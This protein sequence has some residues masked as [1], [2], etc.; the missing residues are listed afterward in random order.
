MTDKRQVK[1]TLG[2]F[3]IT[4]RTGW[5]SA[6]LLISDS[7]GDKAPRLVTLEVSGPSDLS[8]IRERLDNIEDGWRK[9]L[10]QYSANPGTEQ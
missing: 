10:A 9:E 7:S 4:A 8:Y 2:V 5:N 1:V 6:A 3:Y